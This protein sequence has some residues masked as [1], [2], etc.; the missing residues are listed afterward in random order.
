M[1][2]IIITSWCFLATLLLFNACNNGQTNSSKSKSLVGS[3]WMA[4]STQIDTLRDSV[5]IFTADVV[6]KFQ[7]DTSG[8]MF[9]D[10]RVFMDSKAEFVEDKPQRTPF[11]YSFDNTVG[12]MVLDFE[13][14]VANPEQPK[15]LE[16]TF[17][18]DKKE[19]TITTFAPNK[20]EMNVFYEVK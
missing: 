19:N 14:Q 11:T 4:S 6:L 7:D 8:V 17:K 5:F 10:Y 20:T 3:T 1:K 16:N 2:K 18:Y 15:L 12:K 13:G 9:S